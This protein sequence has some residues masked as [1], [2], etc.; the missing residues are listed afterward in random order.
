M[1]DRS[2]GR[3]MVHVR[4]DSELVRQID[5]LA[6]DWRMYRSEVMERLLNEALGRYGNLIRREARVPLTP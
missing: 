6:V 1:A 2:Q 4:L 5:Y 3:E